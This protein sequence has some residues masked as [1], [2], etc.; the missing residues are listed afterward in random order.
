[1]EAYRRALELNP[2]FTRTRYNLGIS[3]VSLG[4]KRE[5]IQHFLT[6]LDAQRSARGPTGEVGKMSESVWDTLRMTLVMSDDRKS[7]DVATRRDLDTLMDTYM[8][9][10]ISSK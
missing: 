1:V 6:A 3:C 10:K 2:G 7:A 9:P 4:A 8:V 5:G